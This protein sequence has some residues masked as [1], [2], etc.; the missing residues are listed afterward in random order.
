ML[1]VE[2]LL[3]NLPRQNTP[4][5]AMELTRSELTES[6]PVRINMYGTSRPRPEATDKPGHRESSMHVDPSKQGRAHGA[7]PPDRKG[8]QAMTSSQLRRLRDPRYCCRFY[9][10][11][12]EAPRLKAPKVLVRA[13][14]SCLACLGRRAVGAPRKSWRGGSSGEQLGVRTKKSPD[15]LRGGQGFVGTAREDY[16]QTDMAQSAGS[17]ESQPGNAPTGGG[18][19][20][21]R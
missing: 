6:T 15:R 20:M 12:A 3:S 8:R 9:H 10:S 17:A 16:G 21:S 13:E 5:L 1:I 2:T 19:P 7:S 14:I 18:P 4:K 11:A